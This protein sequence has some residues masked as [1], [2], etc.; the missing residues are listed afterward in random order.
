M[1]SLIHVL[2]F[3]EIHPHASILL[4]VGTDRRRPY[5]RTKNGPELT[6]PHDNHVEVDLVAQM[7]CLSFS[8]IR[9]AL[10]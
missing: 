8:T 7:S 10:I 2:D 4:M 9:S 5:S 1:P 6:R 3:T